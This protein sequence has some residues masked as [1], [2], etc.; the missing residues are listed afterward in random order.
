MGSG[1]SRGCRKEMKCEDRDARGPRAS[2]V[3]VLLA[4]GCFGLVI[5]MGLVFVPQW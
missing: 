3:D 1:A 2:R 4:A 5:K